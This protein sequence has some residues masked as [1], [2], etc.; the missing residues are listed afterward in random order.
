ML[1]SIFHFVMT[2][3]GAVGLVFLL[4]H[5]LVMS[6]AFDNPHLWENMKD[7]NGNPVPMPFNPTQ[8]FEVFRW[9]YIPFGAWGVASMILNLVAGIRLRQWRSRTFLLVVAAFNCINFPF[10]TVLGI[11]TI[12]VLTRDAMRAQFEARTA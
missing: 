12:V 7:K 6:T 11:F 2:G 5:Y 1:L 4:F 9:F 10:G 3:L 8:F